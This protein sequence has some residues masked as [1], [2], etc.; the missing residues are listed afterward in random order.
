MEDL[1]NVTAL[2][3][4]KTL[5]KHARTHIDTQRE[6][7]ANETDREQGKIREKIRLK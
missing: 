7:I 1:L 6:S 5:D 4:S 2:E 3:I